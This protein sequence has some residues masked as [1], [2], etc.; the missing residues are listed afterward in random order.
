[1]RP[2]RVLCYAPYN[3]FALPGLYETTILR[4][5]KLRG[6]EVDY[7]LCD[8]L[9]SEC[10]LW[11]TANG[12]ERPDNACALCQ[13]HVSSFVANLGMDFTWLGRYLMPKE[14]REAIRWARSLDAEQLV[15]ATYGAWRVG[16][17]VRASVQSHFRTSHLDVADPEIER[18]LRRY[19]YSGLVACFALDRLLEETA[20][21]ALLV[22]NGRMSSTRVALELARAR[23]IR[24]IAHERGTRDQTWMLIENAGSISLRPYHDYWHA[25][26][27]VPLAADELHDIAR[28]MSERE[29]GRDTGFIPYTTPPQ[30]S[31]EV[32]AELGLAGD[33]PIWV[34]FTSSDD[35]VAGEEDYR[36][37]FAFQHEWVQR[38]ID[39][40]RRHPEID[41]VIRV[42]PNTGSRRSWGSNRVQLE[43]MRRLG[44]TLPANVRMVAPDS[45]ISS[46]TLMDLCTVGLIW[47]STVGIEMAC[48]GKNVVA[49]AGSFISATSFVHAVKDA[50]AYDQLLDPLLELA[51]GAVSAE[52]RRLALRHAYGR[53]FRIPLAFPLVELASVNEG[54]LAYSSLDALR[55]GA[56]E[57]LDRC[58]RIILDGEP[59]CP[60][61]SAEQRSRGTDAEDA[62]LDGFEE[63][64]TWVLAFAEELVSDAGFLSAWASAFEGR[65]DVTLLIHTQAEETAGLVESVTLAG[66]DGDDSP[67]LVAGELDSDTMASVD[68][69]FSRVVRDG[70]MAA[71]PRYEPESLAE[72]AMTSAQR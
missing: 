69:V 51:A 53:Y 10:D 37:A 56:D 22:F 54:R 5:L 28:L 21:D 66:L 34:L 58:A 55:P 48:K 44:E 35:E 23:G 63:R 65:D 50:E 25:W 15:S 72:L 59:V 52:V 61:P 26:G 17:W 70:P 16:D 46:Y 62:F 43:Q 11:Y 36:S 27:D 19:V 49:A 40:A 7:V 45:D 42:H 57:A 29:H 12:A 41:L 32:L 13:A 8:G 9:F 47:A 68:A 14:T 3:R 2:P 67:A 31:T 39:Y 38:T 18:M 24:V 20:P 1:M 33:R 4:S 64:R 30:P 60:P 71:A 6:A